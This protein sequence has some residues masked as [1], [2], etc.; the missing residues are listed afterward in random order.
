MKKLISLVFLLILP[1]STFALSI[2]SLYTQYNDEIE[3]NLRK[4]IYSKTESVSKA[5]QNENLAELE[6]LMTQDFAN[7]VK[8][9]LPRL[10]QQLKP[11]FIMN[12]ITLQNDYYS[13][14]KTIGENKTYT[15]SAPNEK[16]FNINGIR[17]NDKSFVQFFITKKKGIQDLIFLQYVNENN[18]WK[19]NTIGGGIYSFENMNTIDLLKSSKRYDNKN[20][21]LTSTLYAL[22]AS[23]ILRPTSY[24][25]YENENKSMELIQNSL[26]KFISKDSFPITLKVG[27][28]ISLFKFDI[29]A[30]QNGLMPMVKYTTKTSLN[31]QELLENES[32]EI[33]REIFSKYPD[34]NKNFD[35]ILFQAHKEIPIDPNKQY[36]IYTSVLKKGKLLK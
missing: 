11:I 29:R 15:I 36:K 24:L 9:V 25:Q 21:Y 32:V 34:L 10:V 17:I 14:V 19:L 35:F 18:N 27:N 23:K 28:N 26:K 33:S 13:S 8:N 30:S 6:K 22:A 20:E 7:K 12:E 2:N 16:S 3:P 4:T 5:F 1:I 31:S